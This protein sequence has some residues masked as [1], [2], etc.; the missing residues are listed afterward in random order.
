MGASL[1]VSSELPLHQD[2]SE[3]FL[4]ENECSFILI[5]VSVVIFFP[6]WAEII[7]PCLTEFPRLWYKQAVLNIQEYIYSSYYS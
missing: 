5:P 7:L 6:I 1:S 4:W 2:H 3:A